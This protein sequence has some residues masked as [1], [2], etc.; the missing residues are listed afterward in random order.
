M[1]TQ[2]NF[3]KKS[4]FSTTFEKLFQD[5]IIVIPMTNKHGQKYQCEVPKP[6]D[7]KESETVLDNVNT[8]DKST[9]E[10]VVMSDLEKAKKLLEPMARY[11]LFFFV[12]TYLHF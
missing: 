1:L 7:I 8:N 3:L 5:D 2:T 9:E 10:V 11:S 6:K 4:I 12:F